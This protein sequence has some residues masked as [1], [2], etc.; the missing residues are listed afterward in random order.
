MKPG[1]VCCQII[2]R[3][4][5]LQSPS[6]CCVHA[7]R[8]QRICDNEDLGS[9]ALPLVDAILQLLCTLSRDHTSHQDLERLESLAQDVMV[10]AGEIGLDDDAMTEQ[11]T[12]DMRIVNQATVDRVAVEVIR[13]LGSTL[14]QIEW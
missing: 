14:Q 1:V 8:C 6:G 3:L 9:T 10:C 11:G 12:P 13:N 2:Q 5:L 7:D 4:S